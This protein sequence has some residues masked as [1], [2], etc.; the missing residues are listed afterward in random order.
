M[1]NS[2]SSRCYSEFTAQFWRES[3]EPTDVEIWAI[4]KNGVG[5]G[6]PDFI[7]W[8][9]QKVISNFAS[10]LQFTFKV[11]WSYMQLIHQPIPNKL[12]GNNRR[13]Y[14]CRVETSS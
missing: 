1:S 2:A 10:S 13:V 8:F 14:E 7:S 6:A 9:K 5:N 4:L 11:G 3:R 12:V